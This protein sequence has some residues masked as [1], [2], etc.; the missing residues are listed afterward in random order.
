MAAWTSKRVA[1]GAV[2]S[3]QTAVFG[4]VALLSLC[5]GGCAFTDLRKDLASLED[6]SFAFEGT[7]T[8][9]NLLSGS[10]IVV[11]MNE[12]DGS[13]IAGFSMLYGAG[14][15]EMLLSPR[16]TYF[17]AFNDLNKDLVFQIDEPFAWAADGRAVGTQ[18]RDIQIAITSESDSTLPFPRQLVGQPL[19]ESYNDR[20]SFALG[21]VTPLTDAHFSEEQAKKGLWEPFSFMADGGTGIHMMSR[22][23]P[24]KVPVL[25]V[26]GILGSPRNFAPLIGSLDRSRY[27]AWVYSYPSGLKLDWLSRGLA[28]FLETMHIDLA[29][30]RL[31]VVAHSMGGLVARGMINYCVAN[32]TCDYLQSFTAISTPWD[33]VDSA[34][35]GVKWAPTVV[36]VWRDLVPDS[37]FVEPLFDTE[38]PESLPFH[39]L[40]GYR[41]TSVFGAESSDGVIKLASQLRHSAQEQADLIRGYDQNHV[42]ILSD[43]HL[44]DQVQ[45]ILDGVSLRGDRG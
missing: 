29:Y 45:S 1:A 8:T 25:F 11:A 40:F 7:V 36:P 42:D 4:A 38:L 22:Y 35:A 33:G 14:E 10:L 34:R 2:Y 43:E 39:L 26:H 30:D 6:A 3:T 20:L 27:Q 44:L 15:F 31:H 37:Q 12:V 18:T 41:Q 5:L 19:I 13:D 24:D 21:T 28:K 23:D 9:H 32:G 17:F 16:S